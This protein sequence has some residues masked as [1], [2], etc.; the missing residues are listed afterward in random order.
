MTERK[1][2]ALL[3][4]ERAFTEDLAVVGDGLNGP[5]VA[6]FGAE[7]GGGEISGVAREALAGRGLFVSDDL[8]VIALYS[9]GRRPATPIKDFSALRRSLEILA[10]ALMAFGAMRA[11]GPSFVWWRRVGEAQFEEVQAV[12]EFPGVFEPI[13]KQEDLI[14]EAQDASERRAATTRRAISRTL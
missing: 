14:R 9:G 2:S 1:A 8:R 11:F 10:L 7:T 13:A 12:G 6:I 4:S 3:I 5:L